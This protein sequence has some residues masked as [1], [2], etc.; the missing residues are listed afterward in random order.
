[1]YTLAVQLMAPT[2]KPIA[3]FHRH[4]TTP[5]GRTVKSKGQFLKL[6]LAFYIY[7]GIAFF[8]RIVL[9]IGSS[10]F[11]PSEVT[12]LTATLLLNSNGIFPNISP[13]ISRFL[14]LY[15]T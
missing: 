10:C 11:V 13:F 7:F 2:I 9:Y 3:D 14:N 6:P 1:M 15:F 5:V 8:S 4:A 12:T